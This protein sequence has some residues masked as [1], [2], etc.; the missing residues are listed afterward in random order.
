MS[1]IKLRLWYNTEVGLH[2]KE[3]EGIDDI[4]IITYKRCEKNIQI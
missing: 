1:M 4:Y 2:Y 3:I